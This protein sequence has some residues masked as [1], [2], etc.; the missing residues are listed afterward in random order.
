[1]NPKGWDEQKSVTFESS[2]DS[3]LYEMHVRD[4]TIDRHS[5]ISKNI[6]GKFLGLVEEGTRFNNTNIKTGFDHLQELG[7]NVVHLLPSF[8][9]KTVDEDI[10]NSNEYN[11]GYDP[12]N[13]NA[14]EGS[15]STNPF[16]GDVRIREFQEMIMK[17][18]EKNIKVLMDVVYNHTY[19]SKNSNFKL[20]VPNY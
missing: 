6:K 1:M 12:L 13:Y 10:I 2:L 11:W 9:Y 8:D 18:H 16:L 3:I 20:I 19:D 15:Y 17:F 7:I 5:G 14:I 4:F